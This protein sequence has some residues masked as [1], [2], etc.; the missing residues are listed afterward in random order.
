MKTVALRDFVGIEQC[1]DVTRQALLDFS[2]Q[3]AIGDLDGAFNS[4]KLIKNERVWFNLAKR[5]V[6]TKRL[7]VAKVCLANMGNARAAAALR[8]A[9]KEPELDAQVAMLALQ[10]GMVPE[11]EKLYK[12][13]K[14]F[15]LLNK[16]Y[17]SIGRWDEA[18]DIANKHDRL[19][20]RATHY[21]YAKKLEWEKSYT[22]AVKHYE[23]SKT[24]VFEV[25][26]MLF[27]D[28]QAL[29]D[30]V[31][32]NSDPALRKWWAQYQ[33]FCGEFEQAEKYYQQCQDYLSL[34]RVFCCLER[35]DEADKLANETGD[36]AACYHMARHHESAG[37]IEQAIHFFTQA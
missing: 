36:Y 27:D 34:V 37:G 24:N 23:E 9:Q 1:D 35:I 17:Q 20:L 33:E 7:D 22:E 11:A 4:I 32:N 21:Q 12:Q 2:R 3:M 8:K 15:D 16:F 6:Y 31:S 14:R 13:A 30:Y 26:R 18:L 29:F 28:P 19:H 25:P 5:C 10:L